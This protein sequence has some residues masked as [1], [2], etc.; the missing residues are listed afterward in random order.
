MHPVEWPP[1]SGKHFSTCEE[2]LIPGAE[3]G[4]AICVCGTKKSQPLGTGGSQLVRAPTQ[5]L[6]TLKL[7]KS[8]LVCSGPYFSLEPLLN[9]HFMCKKDVGEARK[10]VLWL[11]LHCKERVN[12]NLRHDHTLLNG[13]SNSLYFRDIICALLY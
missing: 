5:I 10:Y 6:G 13:A 1:A 8:L 7:F 4:F 12:V 2:S 9:V 11:F 3:V